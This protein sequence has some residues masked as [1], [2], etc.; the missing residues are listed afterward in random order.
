MAETLGPTHTTPPA[1]P[2][3][4]L[5]LSHLL[6]AIFSGWK[7]QGIQFLIL[8]NYEGLPAITTNDVDVLVLPSQRAEAERVMIHLAGDAGYFL[9]NR[10]EFAT[11]SYFFHHPESLRQIQI[12]LFSS[13]RWHAFEV[14]STETVLARRLDRGLFDIP[15]PAHEAVLDLITRLLYQGEVREKYRPIILAGFK[16]HSEVARPLMEAAFGSGWAEVLVTQSLRE[17]WAALERAWKPLRRTLVWRRCSRH[18]WATL[19]ALCGD[20]ARGLRRVLQPGGMTVV[21]LGADGSGKST[22]GDRIIENLKNTFNPGKGLRV[23]WKPVVFFKSRRRS[24]TGPNVNPHGQKRRS[25]FASMLYLGG[26]WLEFVA[27]SFLVFFPALFKNGLVLVDRYHYDFEVDPRRFR[28]QVPLWLVRGLFRFLKA[29]DLVF[30]CDAP[31]EVLQSR[32]QEVPLA[33]TRRQVEA[34]RCL[35]RRL[36]QGRV[37]DA[38][39]PPDAVATELTRQTLDAMRQRVAR[40]MGVR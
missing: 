5:G 10:V 17:D 29:P 38:T 30:L 28:L 19:K 27:G 26:H 40:R 9:H 22:V 11:I 24:N 8:R 16:A 12:D 31:P 32:K 14:V 34:Y 4:D 20:V 35:V 7:S 23:H 6:T 36:P 21:I 15:H 13:L 2:G 25:R 39:Q 3:P 1:R 18:P 37:L 33:E